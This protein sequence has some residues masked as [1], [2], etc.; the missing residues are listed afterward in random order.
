MIDALEKA[1][2]N[3]QDQQQQ[4]PPP[5]QQGQPQDQPLV[6]LIAEL[7]LIRALEARIQRRTERYSMMLP[8]VEDEVGQATQQE[9]IDA[10]Q[11]LAERQRRVEEVTREI[12][13][14]N[15]K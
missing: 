9:L 12:V 11:E 3:M 6:D 1:Q 8:D 15:S 14:E 4:P 10:V 13:L 2:Q 7:K 5:G